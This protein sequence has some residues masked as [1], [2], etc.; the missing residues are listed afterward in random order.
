MVKQIH[1]VGAVIIKDG[2]VLGAQRGPQ[3]NLPGMWE[4]P[5]GKVEL[6]ES[7]AAALERE[8]REELDCAVEVGRAITTTKHE[9]EFGEV[10]LTTFYC[11]I[12]AGTPTLTEHVAVKWLRPQ[13][14]DTLPWAPAD[15]PAV[16]LIRA[17]HAG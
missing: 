15:V 10:I 5:G 6:G 2:F 13:E 1:V 9:Y 14:L 16:N 17:D 11:T 3:G 8:I 7:P 4:F 12:V